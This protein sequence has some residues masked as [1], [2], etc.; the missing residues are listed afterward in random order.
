MCDS[1]QLGPISWE[2]FVTET[3]KNADRAVRL[4]CS[5]QKYD[6][7]S[8]FYHRLN[9]L[10]LPYFI[11][12]RS[13]CLMYRQYHQFKCIPLEPPIIFGRTSSYCTRTPVYFDNV[14]V[15]RLSFPRRFFVLKPHNGGIHCHSL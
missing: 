10:P 15:S 3:S 12:F 13:L 2:Y 7:V 11:Q 1:L 5:L 4:C 14:P 8:A 9:W 6:H